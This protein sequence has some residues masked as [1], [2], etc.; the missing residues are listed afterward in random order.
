MFTQSFSNKLEDRARRERSTL[1]YSRWA[2][3][4]EK[5]LELAGAY[6]NSFW[7][8]YPSEA[9]WEWVKKFLD[10]YARFEVWGR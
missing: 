7:P 6:K 4:S 8:S 3:E 9:H 1:R 5:R 2:K 10:G